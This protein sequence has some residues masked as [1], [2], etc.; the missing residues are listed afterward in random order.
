MAQLIPCLGDDWWS[1]PLKFWASV[2]GD[3]TELTK[4]LVEDDALETHAIHI[5][6][7]FEHAP[8]TSPGARD[9]IHDLASWASKHSDRD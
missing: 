5:S 3:I 6:E 9:G 1:E 7:M 4:K 8:F 2:K